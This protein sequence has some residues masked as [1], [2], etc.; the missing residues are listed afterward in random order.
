MLRGRFR[1]VLWHHGRLR[2]VGR[3]AVT[4]SSGRYNELRQISNKP[5][6]VSLECT[7]LASTQRKMVRESTRRRIAASSSRTISAWA[8]QAAHQLVAFFALLTTNV[9]SISIVISVRFFTSFLFVDALVA[10]SGA[11]DVLSGVAQEEVR[12]THHFDP[13]SLRA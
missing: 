12:A 3:N 1:S 10:A 9:L 8:L 4:I 2:R 6:A 13:A 7:R 11:L 5:F